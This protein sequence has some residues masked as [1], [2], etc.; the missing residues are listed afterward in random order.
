M[1]NWSERQ[2][3]LCSSQNYFGYSLA[4]GS[5][6]SLLVLPFLSSQRK[7]I[8]CTFIM[9]SIVAQG[10]IM[11]QEH[12]TLYAIMA[13]GFAW[14]SKTIVGLSYALEFYPENSK[15]YIFIAY[16]LLNGL[17]IGSL[18]FFYSLHGD[19][20]TLQAVGLILSFTSF[21]YVILFM[22]ESLLVYSQNGK[23]QT[24]RTIMEGLLKMNGSGDTRLLFRFK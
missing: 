12:H 15:I 6:I 20:Y 14:P 10:F 22:P 18:P 2:D 11:L 4:L 19:W 9:I 21:C 1:Q 3:V 13:V 24:V 17:I 8:Y 7:P 23:H 16:I 5:L